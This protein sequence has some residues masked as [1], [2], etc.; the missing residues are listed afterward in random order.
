M[1]CDRLAAVA[2]LVGSHSRQLD[3][4]F[5]TRTAPGPCPWHGMPAAP[6]RYAAKMRMIFGGF[7]QACGA[8]PHITRSNSG[9]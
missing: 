1:E 2:T 8:A 5:R 9:D 3:R 4:F 6:F 7:V